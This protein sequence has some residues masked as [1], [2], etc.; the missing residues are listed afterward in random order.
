MKS[1]LVH[2]T[3]I[4]YREAGPDDGQLILL[5]HGVAS[6]SA[7][8][9]LALPFLAEQGMHALAP[10][11]PGHGGS[12]PGHGDYSLGAFATLLRDLL[13]TLGLGPTTVVGHSMGGGIALQLAH[14]FPELT[15]RL[16]LS[17]SGGLGVHAHPLLRAASAPG[18]ELVLPLVMNRRVVWAMNRARRAMD[19]RARIPGLLSDGS[20]RNYGALS[21]PQGRRVFLA[22]LRSVINHTGQ[23]VT[24][25]GRLHLTGHLP[26]LLISCQDDPAIPCSH[27]EAAHTELP[28]SRLEILPGRS[29]R[30]HQRDPERFA[31]VLA[32]FV[33]TTEPGTGPPA[34]RGATTGGQPDNGRRR[35][36]DA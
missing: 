6:Q 24:A 10:D 30:P 26:T 27:T 11:L 35:K 8:W 5:I 20:L 28:G 17:A 31:E 3:R 1:V 18:A 13:F 12:D 36:L 29:H 7:T 19:G 22:T 34:W 9:D 14:Q 4:I 15:E 33:R 21:T 32:D 16:V 25:V 2:G 23:R